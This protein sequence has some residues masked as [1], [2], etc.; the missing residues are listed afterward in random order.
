MCRVSHFTG[1]VY[2]SMHSMGC[3]PS[4][5]MHFEWMSCRPTD[6]PDGAVEAVM[7]SQQPEN[8]DPVSGP[9]KADNSGASNGLPEDLEKQPMPPPE[10]D[11]RTP[12]RQVLKSGY[13]SAP[14]G[15]DRDYCIESYTALLAHL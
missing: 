6:E 13:R 3:L 1:D 12:F 5:P 9:G 4:W 2:E 14:A 15:V 11:Y 8:P 7:K 10:V